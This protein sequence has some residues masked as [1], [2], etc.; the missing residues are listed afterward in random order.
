MVETLVEWLVQIPLWQVYCIFFV[1][2][3]L[4]NIIPPI[5]GDVLLAFGGY[6][7]SIESLNSL[8]IWSG[9]TILSVIGFMNVYQVGLRWND[10]DKSKIPWSIISRLYKPKLEQ[11]VRRAMRKWGYGIIAVN[12]FLAGTRTVI[13]LI[14]GMAK[15]DKWK[16][17]GLSALSSASWNALLLFLGYTVG[18]N[19]AVIGTYL[20]IYAKW[21]IIL[22]AFVIAGRYF[23]SLYKKK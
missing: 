8:V 21:L 19:W 15:M 13:S 14:A 1:I 16:V 20:A 2:A 7:I 11:R 10:I 9:S 23:T 5:P 12:R 4:E 3:Y 22:V 6:L 17:L 18:E